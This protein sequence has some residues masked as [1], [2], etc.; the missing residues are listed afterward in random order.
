MWREA[1]GESGGWRGRRRKA[2]SDARSTV[3]AG[4]QQDEA[5]DSRQIAHAAIAS[6]LDQQ[7]YHAT[8]QSFQQ[9]AARAGWNWQGAD[10][11]ETCDAVSLEGL[12]EV[13]QSQLA[14]KR[15]DTLLAKRITSISPVNL[16][17]PGP[18][19]LDFHVTR[20]HA[21]LHSSNI[22]SL[23]LVTLPTHTFSTTEARYTTQERRLICSTAADKRIVLSD[24]DSGEMFEVFEPGNGSSADDRHSA[25][26]LWTSQNPNKS[27][28]REFVSCGMDAK[29]VVWDLL[30]RKP[31]QVLRNHTKFVVKCAFSSSGEYLASCSYDK[32]VCIYRRRKPSAGQA[33]LE[34]SDGDND[35]EIAPLLDTTYEL[36]HTTTTANN[37]ESI[38]FVRARPWPSKGDPGLGMEGRSLSDARLDDGELEIEADDAG[39]KRT[40]LAYT[41]RSDSCIHYIALPVDADELGAGDGSVAEV[42]AGMAGAQV[43]DKGK[44]PADWTV[45]HFNTNEK[46]SDFHVSYSLMHLTLHPS[47]E[48]VC[49]QTGDHSIPS[50]GYASSS[51][52]LSRILVLPL[53]SSLRSTTLWTGVESTGFAT[54]RHDWLPDGSAAWVTSEEGCVRLID[55]KGKIR[56]KVTAHGGPADQG[57]DMTRAATWTR[58]GNS[59][60]KS[61]VVLD[62]AGTVATCGYDRTV[63]IVART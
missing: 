45:L 41:M 5:V 19:T 33:A 53:L 58:G 44:V 16:T 2:L 36:V 30:H 47:Q 28:Q 29:V 59:L 7:G 43:Q 50:S 40:W 34:E 56:A 22:L 17:L 63:R 57:N 15:R 54:I 26:V 1:R 14:Q 3:M 37:P 21:S 48:H 55:T 32:T 6:F 46:R 49:I 24:A 51:S 12:I 61:L 23:S 27:N 9:D 38:L 62:E 4:R 8:L 10:E 52:S 20:T 42:T 35:G 11:A 18:S 31:I 39:S 60:I 25:A 13:H